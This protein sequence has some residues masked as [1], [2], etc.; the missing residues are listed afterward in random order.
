MIILI[1][2]PKYASHPFGECNR[3]TE[4]L[5]EPLGLLLTSNIQQ[6]RTELDLEGELSGTRIRAVAT[7]TV[8]ATWV[9]CAQGPGLAAQLTFGMCIFCDH[10]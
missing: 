3:D 8:H 2:G 9:V 4:A 10:I 7:C 5:R 6:K 1:Q